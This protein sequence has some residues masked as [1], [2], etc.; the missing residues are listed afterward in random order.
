[1]DQILAEKKAEGEDGWHLLVTMSAAKG[2]AR[3]AERCFAALSMTVF[4]CHP[5][6]QRKVWLDDHAMSP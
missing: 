5:E 3:W 6:P 2:L 4:P 1:V